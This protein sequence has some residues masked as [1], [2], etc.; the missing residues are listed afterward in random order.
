M[1]QVPIKISVCVP[2]YNRAEVLPALL[3]SVLT[4]DFDEFE[5]V[6]NEDSSPE[7]PLIREVV[8]RYTAQF[9]NRIRYFENEINLGYDANLRSL[10]ERSRGE[11]CLFMGNDD[12]MCPSA[13]KTISDTISRHPKVGVYLRSFAAFDSTPSNIVQTFKYFDR[14]IFF[15]AG[16]GTISTFFKRSVVIPG[17]TL[18]RGVALQFASNKFD[19]TLLYQIYL[20]ANILV[21]WNGVFSPEIVTLYRNGGIPDFGN[22]DSEKGKFVPRTR[23]VQS[24]IS[25]MRGMLDI[26]KYVEAQHHVKVYRA[27]LQDLANYSYPILSVQADKPVSEFFKYYV[28]LIRLG[29]GQ[30]LLFHVYFFAILLLGT[31]RMERMI[32]WSK[33]KLGHTPV[34]GSVYQGLPEKK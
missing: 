3:E 9:P 25:F 32:G 33:R 16:A 2:A 18:H 1:N 6:I 15:P 19:G 4:Q 31:Q 27:I 20:V 7:R 21:E 5:V 28:A 22:S 12:L 29:F 10:I 11:Y 17:V 14:E 8:E 24:S 34:I 30:Q 26:A 13:L 23:T